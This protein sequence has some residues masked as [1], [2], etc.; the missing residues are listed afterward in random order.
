MAI[1][2][3][4]P[5]SLA[6]LDLDGLKQINDVHGHE[7]GDRTLV[8]F[9]RHLLKNFRESDVVAR[10]GGDEFCV[11]MSGA[12]EHD[13][14]AGLKRLEEVLAARGDETIRFSAGVA[15]LDPGRHVGV[16]DLLREADRRM[17]E[18]K[19]GKQEDDPAAVTA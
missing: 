7:A 11:L 18:C 8:A 3:G 15:T 4:L 13:V 19:R 17:Y 6:Q 5:L 16:G 12:S 10:L 2:H 9:A 1:R 14:S